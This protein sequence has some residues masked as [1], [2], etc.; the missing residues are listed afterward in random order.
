LA[1]TARQSGAAA[2]S[3]FG[4]GFGGSVWALVPT[5][6]VSEFLAQWQRSYLDRFPQHEPQAAFFSTAAG[7]ALCR[8]A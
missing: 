3:A 7:P 5:D 2:A 1:A 6:R 8:V 4:A